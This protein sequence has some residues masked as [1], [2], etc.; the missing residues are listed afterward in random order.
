MFAFI[1]AISS[2]TNTIIDKVILT[3]RRMEIRVFI[4]VL[5]MFLMLLTGLFV[6]SLGKVSSLSLEPKYLLAFLGMLV[7]AAVW[8]IFYYLGAQ[9]E[10]VQ[11]FEL[12]MMFQPLFTIFLAAILIERNI[13]AHVFI[14]SVLAAIALII[15]HLKKK[16]FEFD[17]YSWGLILAVVFMSVEIILQK[18]LL[19]A[20]SPV[21]L[22]F[23]RTLVL[24]VFFYFF[25]RP[26]VEQISS[27]NTWLILSSSALGV[28]QM[29]TKFY[30]FE[31]YGVIYTSLIL[32]LAPILVYMLSKVTLHEKLKF[33][34]VACA[35]VILGCIVYATTLGK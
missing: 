18:I 17:Q 33:R 31:K 1:S 34:T 2:A 30:G 13:N 11:E 25:Y 14:A 12:I 15:A 19:E 21:A 4:P 9:K 32:I 3:R 16:H 20:Y 6:P 5:F 35:V 23:L 10:K 29:V 24:F 22:Y 28:V 27:T 7:A 26:R 8:N